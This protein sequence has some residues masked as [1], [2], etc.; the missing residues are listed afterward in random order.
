MR[1]Q[2]SEHFLA[3]RRN[4]RASE[5]EKQQQKKPQLSVKPFSFF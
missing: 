3:E 2:Q 4:H 1:V 5:R